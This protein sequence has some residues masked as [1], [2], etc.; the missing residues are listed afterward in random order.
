MMKARVCLQ[1]NAWGSESLQ[2]SNP[3]SRSA[4]CCGIATLK[5]KLDDVR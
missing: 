1:E 4:F 5:F 2:S 3:L